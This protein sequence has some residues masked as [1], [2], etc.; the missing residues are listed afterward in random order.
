MYL[1]GISI[2]QRFGHRRIISPHRGGH[3]ANTSPSMRAEV[4]SITSSWPSLMLPTL[5][6]RI[7]FLLFLGFWL[8]PVDAQDRKH[9]TTIPNTASQIVWTPP[10]CNTSSSAG[11]CTSEWYAVT[12]TL[13][14]RLNE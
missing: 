4:R 3:S 9:N 13:T 2:G 10:P 8:P 7:L 11:N 6:T 12:F 5:R 14:S 1:L